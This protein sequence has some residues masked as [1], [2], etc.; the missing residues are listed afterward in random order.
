M[1]REPGPSDY[2]RNIADDYRMLSIVADY[3]G[4]TLYGGTKVAISDYE[5]MLAG[6]EY[7]RMPMDGIIMYKK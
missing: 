5:F 3:K 1:Y 2:D 6:I 7:K 4:G